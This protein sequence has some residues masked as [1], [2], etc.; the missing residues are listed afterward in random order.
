MPRNADEPFERV[1]AHLYASD[2]EFI[3]SHYGGVGNLGQNAAIRAMV[4]AQVRR[5]R[6]A[7]EAASSPLADLGVS[8]EDLV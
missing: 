2:L 7:K 1:H 4:R 3:R 8:E 6:A 5:L